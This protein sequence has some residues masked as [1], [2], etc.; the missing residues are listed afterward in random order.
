MAKQVNPFIARRLDG[1]RQWKQNTQTEMK[2]I[3]GHQ[4][5]NVSEPCFSDI[6]TSSD[7]R[8]SKLFLLSPSSSISSFEQQYTVLSQFSN[9]QTPNNLVDRFR[10]THYHHAERC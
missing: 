10:L 2:R 6:N 1:H 3:T 5:L 7:A 4:S 9:I 8:T